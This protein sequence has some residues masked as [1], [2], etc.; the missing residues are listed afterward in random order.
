LIDAGGDKINMN[1]GT[2]SLN[3]S[4]VVGVFSL[5]SSGITTS[6]YITGP[7]SGATGGELI[8]VT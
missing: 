6:V 3:P 8:S 1:A 4:G 7:T 2:I 5:T